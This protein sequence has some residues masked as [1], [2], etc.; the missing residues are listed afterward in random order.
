MQV[1]ERTAKAGTGVGERVQPDRPAEESSL[2]VIS[3]YCPIINGNCVRTSLCQSKATLMKIRKH[4]PIFHAGHPSRYI[5]FLHQGV[6]GVFRLWET[7]EESIVTVLGPGS[8]L[9]FTALRSG[10]KRHS[11]QARAISDCMVC[12]IEASELEAV[13]ARDTQSAML[14]IDMLVDRLLDL[15][16][17]TSVPSTQRVRVR[18]ASLLLSL[19]DKSGQ[20]TAEGICIPSTLTHQE[21]A[22]VISSTRATVTREL[23]EMSSVGWVRTLPGAI[24]ITDEHALTQLVT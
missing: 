11:Y 17:Y 22:Y 3:D 20:K 7:G 13:M 9:G 21:M 15:E 14:V 12:R 1:L 5:Y 19:A 24:I 16:T 4:K 10:P 8:S 2:R 23:N 18:L 6:V